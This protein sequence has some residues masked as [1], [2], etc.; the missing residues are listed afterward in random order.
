MEDAE[1][2][3]IIPNHLFRNRSP[4]DSGLLLFIVFFIYQMYPYDYGEIQKN[5]IR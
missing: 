1:R 3:I 2:E 4:E 5:V